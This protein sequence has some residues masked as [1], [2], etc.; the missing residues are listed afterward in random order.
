LKFDGFKTEISKYDNIYKEMEQKS[1]FIQLQINESIN[2]EH[3]SYNNT[4]IINEDI[5]SFKN[6]INL[7]KLKISN[8]KNTVTN[9][10]KSYPKEF[11]F[12]LEDIKHEKELNQVKIHKSINI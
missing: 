6:E 10:E 7:N 5:L 1:D 9:I 3:V 4:F 8:L 2:Q 11:E 12:L